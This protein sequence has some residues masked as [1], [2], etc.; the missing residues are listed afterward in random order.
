MIIWGK[1]QD[2]REIGGSILNA[3]ANPPFILTPPFWLDLSAAKMH[4]L[5]TE[6]QITDFTEHPLKI[7]FYLQED[8][9]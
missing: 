6:F 8:S 3:V 9:R 1:N 7:E 4:I 2:H 5:S